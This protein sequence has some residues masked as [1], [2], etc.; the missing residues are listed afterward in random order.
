M[1]IYMDFEQVENKR[2]TW[3]LLKSRK[4]CKYGN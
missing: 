4:S 3:A 1:Y 2:G